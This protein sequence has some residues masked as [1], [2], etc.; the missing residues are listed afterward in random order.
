[1]KPMIFQGSKNIIYSRIKEARKNLGMTQ[2]ELAGK[3]Q[4]LGVN[5][6]Q[7][8]ISKIENNNRIVTDFELKCFS[9]ALKVDVLYLLQDF[10][11]S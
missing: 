5:I 8:M 10:K 6:D 11:L 3:M 9:I 7:Q 1:M 4:T 2:E